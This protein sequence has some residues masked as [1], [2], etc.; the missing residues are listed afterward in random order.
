M[1]KLLDNPFLPGFDDPERTLDRVSK[2]SA[3]G[4]PPYDIER[5]G[6]QDTRTTLAVASFS[7]RDLSI[8]NRQLVIRGRQE[9][10]PGREFLHRGIATRRFQC[11]FVLADGIEI[12]GAELDNGL[13]RIDLMKSEAETG[14]R[15]IEIQAARTRGAGTS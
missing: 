15:S 11:S 9:E 12:V 5:I 13:L 7:R 8:E 6:R 10:R 2:S 1:T 3:A 4:Y 14:S